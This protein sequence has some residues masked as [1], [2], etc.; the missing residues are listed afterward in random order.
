MKLNQLYVA[1]LIATLPATSIFAAA[2]E[3]SNQSI[4]AFLEP[5]NYFEAGFNVTDQSIS[6][7]TTN[8]I[9]GLVVASAYQNLNLGDLNSTFL[10]P[11]LTIKAQIN[12]KISMGL[13]YDEPFGIDTNYEQALLY[14]GLP[15]TKT[16][17]KIDT[18]NIT[19]LFGYQ[20]N[21]NWN[22]F[23]GPSYQYLNG[24]F[25]PRGTHS[26]GV[27]TIEQSTYAA[28]FNDEAYGWVGGLSFKTND[29]KHLA[30]ITY[31]S[32][33]KHKFSAEEL[34]NTPAFTNLASRPTGDDSL[35]TPQSVNIETNSQINSKTT[36]LAN[37][38]WINWKNFEMNLLDYKHR[39]AN[40]Q[41]NGPIQTG[42]QGG[43]DPIAYKKDQWSI[44]LGVIQKLS[45]KW[46][47]NGSLGWD[48]GVG[49]HISH[50]TPINGSWSAG[51]G[52]QYSPASNYFVQTGIKYIWLDDVKGQHSKQIALNSDQYDT[53]FNN[54]HALSYNF[55]IGYKF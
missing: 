53:E 46:Q 38:R 28:K 18:K 55:K 16:Q 20:P 42:L 6:A 44:D 32:K 13:I 23:L 2:L 39:I 3:R 47:V 40:F 21:N 17:F 24:N 31:R 30:S 41:S 1:T 37:V 43:Y 12:E 51:L 27:Q 49:D 14:L 29:S 48:S 15:S 19:M 11:D 9:M 4:S 22:I 36:L 45:D 35:T 54:N 34:Q 5:G 7:K 52:V 33:I 26:T 8:N 50:Y 10:V 25:T